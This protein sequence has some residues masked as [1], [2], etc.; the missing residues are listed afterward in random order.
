MEERIPPQDIDAEMS[1]LGAM[2]LSKDA[3]HAVLGRLRPEYFYKDA[4]MH[5]YTAMQS[6]VNQGEPVD[7]LSVAAELKKLNFLGS[8]GGK[9]YLAEVV[10]SVPTAANVVHYSDIVLEKAVLRKLIDV[11][12]EMVSHAFDDS[13]DMDDILNNA[14]REINE[15]SKETISNDLVRLG[16]VVT[17]AWD[18]INEAFENEDHILGVPTGFSDLDELTSGFQKSDLLILA[19]RPAMGKTALAINFAMKAAIDHQKAVAIFSCEM[20]KEQIALRMLSAEARVPMSRLKTAKIADDE[21]RGLS[22]ALGKLSECPIYIDDTPS[23]SPMA[24]RA[25]C[26]RL[27]AEADLSMVIIDYLQLM[28]IGKKRVESRFQEVS[29]IVRELKSIAKELNV[30]VMALSQLSRDVEKRGGD[31]PKLSDLR[32]SGEIEQTA[33]LVMFIHRDD[34]YDQDNNEPV[35]PTSIVIAKHRNGPTGKVDLVFRKDVSRFENA[36]RHQPVPQAAPQ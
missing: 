26:R 3:T 31:I 4:H 25:K 14:Q 6:L 8:S 11:G 20:P 18:N 15:V 36:I 1:V 22:N 17:V 32:E 35:S 28:R 23:I 33:D 16:S 10:N 19:A 21:Y 2:M 24:M 27:Q 5:I 7:S 29:E 12:G 34:Y 9:G 13:L 30:P